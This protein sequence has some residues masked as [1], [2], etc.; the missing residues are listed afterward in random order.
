[1]TVA[2]ARTL[3]TAALCAPVWADTEFLVIPIPVPQDCPVCEICEAPLPPGCTR[4]LVSIDVYVA[5][6]NQLVLNW[7][8]D[9]GPPGSLVFGGDQC[10]LL[11]QQGSTNTY[12]C[13]LSWDPP[14][15][16]VFQ[17]R[18]EYF[19]NLVKSGCVQQTR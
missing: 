2:F 16:G 18:L 7:T 1:M 4:D 8:S 15:P 10:T 3:L 12:R 6:P 13:R 19:G 5:I 11:Y 9:S 14:Y 17:Y